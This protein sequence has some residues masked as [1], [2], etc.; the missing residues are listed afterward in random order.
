MDV[1]GTFVIYVE[2][3]DGV[4]WIPRSEILLVTFMCPLAALLLANIVCFVMSLCWYLRASRGAHEMRDHTWKIDLL[5]SIKMTT[6]MGL[7]WIFGLLANLDNLEFLKFVFVILNSFQGLS[8]FVA[9][10]GSGNVRQSLKA[11]FSCGTKD[12]NTGGTD[13][14]N[15]NQR[16]WQSTN[17]TS[18]RQETGDDK[19]AICLETKAS[20]YEGQ[21]FGI[22]NM[23]FE[24]DTKGPNP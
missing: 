19:D 15:Q 20:S 6:L 13:S 3:A 23:N 18:E 21:K 2:T 24:D 11:R 7:T 12:D 9:Y 10:I 8:I 16:S 5:V 17:Y 22:E 14:Q 4:C 1:V